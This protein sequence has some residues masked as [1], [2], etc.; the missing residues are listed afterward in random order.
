MDFV[1]LV[2]KEDSGYSKESLTQDQKLLIDGMEIMLSEIDN[3][4]ESELELPE[5][6]NDTPTLERLVIEIKQ[7]AAAEIHDW[8]YA[9]MCEYI[10]A[11]GDD[12]ASREE[13]DA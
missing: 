10:V 9:T 1:H 3:Y 4:T 2:E 8:L 11:F 13:T 7:K 6:E 12:N 5:A